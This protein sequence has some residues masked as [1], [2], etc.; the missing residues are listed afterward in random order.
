MKKFT[1]KHLIGLI[2]ECCALVLFV[3]CIATDINDNLFQPLAICC[4]CV[5]TVI[6]L[7]IKRQARKNDK[8]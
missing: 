3:L 2:L 8:D 5:G 4:M 6:I 1:V 7:S